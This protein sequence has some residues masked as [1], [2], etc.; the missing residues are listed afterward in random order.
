MTK[1]HTKKTP[2]YGVLFLSVGGGL[3]MRQYMQPAK[4]MLRLMLRGRR[5]KDA[6]A[7]MDG[8]AKRQLLAAVRAKP[9]AA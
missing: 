4:G 5:G 1:E 9:N 7:V 6:A 8:P 3:F 2:S